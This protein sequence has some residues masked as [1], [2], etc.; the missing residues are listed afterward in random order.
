MDAWEALGL[1]KPSRLQ[2]YRIHPMR[3]VFIKRDEPTPLGTFGVLTVDSRTF[4]C[5]SLELNDHGN[6][7]G[8]SCIPAGTYACKIVSS[9][10]FGAV[11][12]IAG[13]PGRTN[14]LLHKG[15]FAADE[16]HGKSDIEGCVL[17]GNA[18][19]EI[20]GQRCLLSSKDAVGR[21]M[22]EMEGEP[23]ELTIRLSETV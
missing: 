15:N 6:K 16:G 3:K 7:V 21:F 20:A 1:R 2:A 9:P 19:G 4:S 14:V 18:I 5:Y 12:E 22:A 17:L 8:I 23:F 10:K 13:V 11:Y